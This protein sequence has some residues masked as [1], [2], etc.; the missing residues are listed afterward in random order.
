MEEILSKLVIGLRSGTTEDQGL[1]LTQLAQVLDTSFGEDADWLCAFLRSS[2]AVASISLLLE[3]PDAHI[4]Q[5]A[6]LLVGNIAS[7]AVDSQ[8]DA[9]KALLVQTGA[10]QRL[11][12]HLF[13]LL[14]L[15][16]FAPTLPFRR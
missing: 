10:F 1:A 14:C 3:S 4:H 8:S 15:H 5:M 11:L 16:K 12:P 6:C 9:T 7:D 13:T 2:G